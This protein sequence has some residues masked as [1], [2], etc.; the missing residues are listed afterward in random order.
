M[1]H[2]LSTGPE[3]WSGY[4]SFL[5]EEFSLFSQRDFSMFTFSR[6]GQNYFPG[7]KGRKKESSWPWAEE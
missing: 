7:L 2:L 1:Q 5:L 4:N 3:Y 6:P